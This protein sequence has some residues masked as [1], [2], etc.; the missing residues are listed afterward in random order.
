M[1]WI[2]LVVGLLVVT[3]WIVRRERTMPTVTRIAPEGAV[4]ADTIV[5]FAWHSVRGAVRYTIEVA[6]PDGVPVA[7]AAT[8]GDTTIDVSTLALTRGVN[9]RWTVTATDGR[10][11]SS[12]SAAVAFTVAGSTVTGATSTR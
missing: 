8:L 1:R 11:R 2:V 9:Y 10:G 4:H 6:R 12:R 7:S 5:R 3:I